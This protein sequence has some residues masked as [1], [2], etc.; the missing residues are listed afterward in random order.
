MPGPSFTAEVEE[1]INNTMSPIAGSLHDGL[2]QLQ[3][4][5]DAL[6]KALKE[7][8]I[9]KAVMEKAVSDFGTP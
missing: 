7:V 8:Q 6:E 5:E 9:R 2:Y 4:L 1:A 3:M